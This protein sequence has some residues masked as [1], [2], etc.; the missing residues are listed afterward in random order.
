MAR[1]PRKFVAPT[2]NML[3]SRSPFAKTWGQ[4]LSDSICSSLPAATTMRTSNASANRKISSVASASVPNSGYARRD[5]VCRVADLLIT[6]PTTPG[7][8]RERANE[9]FMTD[10]PALPGLDAIS[11]R[12]NMRVSTEDSHAKAAGTPAMGN[13]N[14]ASLLTPKV[15]PPATAPTSF[16]WVSVIAREVPILIPS[17]RIG[18]CVNSVNCCSR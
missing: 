7:P 4:N 16:P 12:A 6:R 9:Q 8:S 14:C 15:K 17:T 13:T 18:W 10:L 1:W 2:S 11:S 5:L 3:F